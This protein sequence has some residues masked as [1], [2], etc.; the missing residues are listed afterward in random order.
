M[1][2]GRRQSWPLWAR[3]VFIALPAA[4][5]AAAAVAASVAL[6]T[7]LTG[8][9]AQADAILGAFYDVARTAARFAVLI[10]APAAVLALVILLI[11]GGY[12]S[13]PVEE[14]SPE[15]LPTFLGR[16]VVGSTLFAGVG[17]I[18]QMMLAA[19]IGGWSP[20]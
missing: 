18:C 12:R 19:Q 9:L 7:I 4:G 16:V 8:S 3:L 2:D 6:T 13:Y 15:H 17:L 14:G 1:I 11:V 10:G 20:W 5:T